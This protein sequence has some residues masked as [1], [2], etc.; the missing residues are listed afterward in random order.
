M[1]DTISAQR[2]G[3][4][5]AGVSSPLK[6]GWEPGASPGVSGGSSTAR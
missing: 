3:L 5:A 6:G 4:G 1:N 2:W